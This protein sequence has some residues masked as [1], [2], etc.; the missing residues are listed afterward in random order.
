MGQGGTGVYLPSVF[1]VESYPGFVAPVVVKSHQTGRVACGLANRPHTARNA[2]RQPAL[3]R[4]DFSPTWRPT[5]YAQ[6][7]TQCLLVIAFIVFVT[8]A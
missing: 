2:M 8:R 7:T 6:S 3:P 5:S 4:V 1:P